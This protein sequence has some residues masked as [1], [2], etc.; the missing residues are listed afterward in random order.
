MGSWF[1]GQR[2]ELLY[3]VLFLLAGRSMGSSIRYMYIYLVHV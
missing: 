1:M 3:L 2:K